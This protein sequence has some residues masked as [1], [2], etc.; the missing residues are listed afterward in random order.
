MAKRKVK[1][2]LDELEKKGELQSI[3][4]KAVKE[5]KGVAKDLGRGGGK[6]LAAFLDVTTK[7]KSDN[8]FQQNINARLS[9]S[10]VLA[11][12]L[13][14]DLIRRFPTHLGWNR[15]EGTGQTTKM[16]ANCLAF[17]TG[18]ILRRFDEEE[19]E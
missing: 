15:R 8:S 2:M 11:N 19:E 10:E 9:A 16:A 3:I 6:G 13:E 12:A 7:T 17:V 4:N 1:T 18:E 14:E 5:S